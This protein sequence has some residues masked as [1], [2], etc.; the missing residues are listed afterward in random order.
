MISM[1]IAWASAEAYPWEQG[2][3]I[4]RIETAKVNFT[5]RIYANAWHVYA[6]LAI[7]NPNILKSIKMPKVPWRCS[8]WC[9]GSL[10]DKVKFKERVQWARRA[11]FKR[12]AIIEKEKY[13]KTVQRRP[14]RISQD[15]LHL[16]SGN[17]FYFQRLFLTNS[18][19][20][21]HSCHHRTIA[22][23]L[24]FLYQLWWIVGHILGDQSIR[25]PW[26]C[27]CTHISTFPG[28]SGG[29]VPV[30]HAARECTAF[31][32]LRSLAKSRWFR[33]RHLSHGLRRLGNSAVRWWRQWWRLESSGK[34]MLGALGDCKITITV[35]EYG[36]WF[37]CSIYSHHF[38]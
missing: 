16:Q 11:M 30:T 28:C 7:L 6:G 14:L 17:Q 33:V 26:R 21:F 12:G 38:H 1:G 24:I 18:V 23:T 3:Y 19:S 25:T 34:K 4:G 35:I 5:L 37:S 13:G 15:P 2:L 36:V 20:Q 22:Q 9:S 8:N 29:F 31:G 27:G 10:E 32:D